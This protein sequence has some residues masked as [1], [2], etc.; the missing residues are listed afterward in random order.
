MTINTY[1]TMLELLLNLAIAASAASLRFNF[2]AQSWLQHCNPLIDMTFRRNRDLEQQAQS[3]AAVAR[4]LGGS[5]G[6]VVAETAPS[7]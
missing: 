2:A 6:V 3:P 1:L 4:G 7:S 5:L